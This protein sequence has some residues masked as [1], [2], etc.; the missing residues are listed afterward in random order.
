M[1]TE[2]LTVLYVGNAN[3]GAR[4]A[5]HAE[6]RGWYVYVAES[7]F[8]ALG[9]YAMYFPDVIILDDAQDR[10]MV[11]AAYFHL[12]SVN[13]QPVLILTD[14]P[15]VWELPLH[16]VARMLPANA[17]LTQLTEAVIDAT[18]VPAQ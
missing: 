4:F 7:L 10:D 11:H 15:G 17:D 14:N 12:A 2:F 18:A 13:A 16:L 9:A 3:A 6:G 5:T 1:S 8:E